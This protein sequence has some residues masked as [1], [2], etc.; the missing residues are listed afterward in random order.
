[1]DNIKGG[2]QAQVTIENGTITAVDPIEAGTSDPES[3][4]VNAFA[5]PGIV[6]RVL[7]AQ[8]ADVEM[9]SG[10]SY[11]SPAFVESV[12]GALAEAQL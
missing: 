1:V 3:V 5:V 11:T 2:Y 10:S 4:R 6:E 8:S 7:E 9:V 12:E